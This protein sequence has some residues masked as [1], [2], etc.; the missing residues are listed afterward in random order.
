MAGL[1]GLTS[2]AR[3]KMRA[4][5]IGRLTFFLGIFVFCAALDGW[6]QSA[7]ALVVGPGDSVEVT[8]FFASPPNVGGDTID[9]LALTATPFT[10]SGPDITATAQLFSGPALLGSGALPS[11]AFIAFSDGL[12]ANAI[13]AT[14]SSITAAGFQGSILFTPV[15]PGGVGYIEFN[16]A[17]FN[18][19]AGHGNSATGVLLA[20]DGATITSISIPT[21][22][23]PVPAALLLFFSALAA[24]GGVLVRRRGGGEEAA[25]A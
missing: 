13:P 17:N 15:F 9:F 21:V 24:L 1:V 4:R 5:A 14:L 22:E 12:Y 20:Q 18:V 19:R 23:T 8:F 11:A 6:R 16:L 3:R 25:T 2:A 10:S 7:S